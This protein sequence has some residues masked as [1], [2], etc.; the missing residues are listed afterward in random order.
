M[1]TISSFSLLYEIFFLRK[2][3][4][5]CLKIEK[6]YNRKIRVFYSFFF[7]LFLLGRNGDKIL[8]NFRKKSLLIKINF[9]L[10]KKEFLEKKLKY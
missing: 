8:N 9:F 10:K 7:P 5:N 6:L 3:K 2:K 1:T 4:I